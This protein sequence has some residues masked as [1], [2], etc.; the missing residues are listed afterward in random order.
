MRGKNILNTSL[1]CMQ[2]CCFLQ[3]AKLL[4]FSKAAKELYISQPT[5]SKHIK[6]LESQLGVQLFIRNNHSIE[7]T[8][9]GYYL[10]NSFSKIMDEINDAVT[11]ARSTNKKKKVTLRL[12]ASSQF[13]SREQLL[14]IKKRIDGSFPEYNFHFQE[15]SPQS[16]LDAHQKSPFD[17]LFIPELELSSYSDMPFMKT[18]HFNV[19]ITL[20]NKHPLLNKENASIE[21][22]SNCVFAFYDDE[23]WKKACF[24]TLWSNRLINPLIHST[25]MFN[26]IS[27]LLSCVKNSDC[28]TIMPD[29]QHEEGLIQMPLKLSSFQYDSYLLWNGNSHITEDIHHKFINFFL[30]CV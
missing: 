26:N 15:L 4:S 22:F 12:G 27:D 17:Y 2:I 11:Y 8:N 16:L 13:F 19:N 20:S 9:T 25:R 28:V 3:A 21:D 24:H 18:Q 5:L 6:A 10:Y 14:N 23:H 1:N 29:L 30:D 7:L